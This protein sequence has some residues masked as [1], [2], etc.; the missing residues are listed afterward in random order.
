MNDNSYDTYSEPLKV[1]HGMTIHMILNDRHVHH[2]THHLVSTFGNSNIIVYVYIYFNE[3]NEIHA[4][5]N[6]TILI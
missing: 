2:M 4:Q 3:P 1:K 6:T 5:F